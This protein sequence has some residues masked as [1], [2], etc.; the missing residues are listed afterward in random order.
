M[1]NSI[2]NIKQAIS[3]G[4]LFALTLG[5]FSYLAKDNLLNLGSED[6]VIILEIKN[7]DIANDIRN[8]Q[9]K[10]IP[11]YSL[12]KE[13]LHS[14]EYSKIIYSNDERL[15]GGCIDSIFELYFNSI[16]IK[17][18]NLI[19]RE[20]FQTCMNNFFFLAF[21]KLKQTFIYKIK[22]KTN[23]N[24]YQLNE[25]NILSNEKCIELQA[26]INKLI[27]RFNSFLEN[28]SY[29]NSDFDF[30]KESLMQLLSFQQNFNALQSL[31][32]YCNS[33]YNLFSTNITKYSNSLNNIENQ[34]SRLEFEQVFKFEKIYFPK[35]Q[36]FLSIRNT[37]LS[38]ALFGFIFGVLIF[39]QFFILKKKK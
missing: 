11:D 2:T 28:D 13:L 4:I 19:D 18:K 12:T 14:F 24:E 7:D 33:D 30:D 3:V 17:K 26:L 23:L 29:L 36:T 22:V 8:L 6:L 34:F 20:K 39:Y 9:L 21:E 10:N 37:V 35:S 31:F 27:N 38:F 5:G 1:K 32:Q 15:S 16:I 25:N